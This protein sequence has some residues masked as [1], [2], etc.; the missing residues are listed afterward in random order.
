MRRSLGTMAALA[1]AGSMLM[2]GCARS[3]GRIYDPRADAAMQLAA[4]AKRAAG[5]DRRVL[6]IIGG[7][8]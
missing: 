8:W 6:A 7:D 1:I 4:A 3:D 5:S 2:A